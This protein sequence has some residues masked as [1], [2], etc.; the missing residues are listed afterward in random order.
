MIVF[1][2]SLVI[3]IVCIFALEKSRQVDVLLSKQT[4]QQLEFQSGFG[5]L[6]FQ[7]SSLENEMSRITKKSESCEKNLKFQ[8]KKNEEIVSK[9]NRSCLQCKKTNKR[10]EKQ[11]FRSTVKVYVSEK[12][13]LHQEE[14]ENV[15][16]RVSSLRQ[17]AIDVEN[18]I[19]KK[20]AN[21]THKLQKEKSSRILLSNQKSCSLTQISSNSS[22]TNQ[23]KED[24]PDFASEHCGATVIKEKGTYRKFGIARPFSSS[25]SR[26]ATIPDNAPGKCWPCRPPCELELQLCFPTKISAFSVHHIPRLISPSPYNHICSQGDYTSR[27]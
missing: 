25:P 18:D 8:K 27:K 10:L 11:R 2:Q 22:K 7:I 5:E 26:F 16:S 15:Q 12:I 6:R 24:L 23:L 20:F 17:I 4:L 14:L 21:L 19:L 3:C 9:I 1:V 13:P